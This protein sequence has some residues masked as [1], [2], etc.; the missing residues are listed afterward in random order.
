MENAPANTSSGPKSGKLWL[1]FIL[2][3]CSAA[4]AAYLGL[5][6]MSLKQK[7][8]PP[9]KAETK[10]PTEQ[11]LAPARIAPSFDA[12]TAD[13]WGGLVAAGQAEPGTI[14]LLQNQGQTL[15]EAKADEHGEWVLMLDHPLPPGNYDLSLQAVRPQTQEPIAGP[16]H[17]AL[18]IAPRE[19]PAAKPAQI[20][21][22]SPPKAGTAAPAASARVE[23]KQAKPRVAAVKRGD[24]LWAMAHRFYG[25][26]IRYGEIAGANKEQ[27]KDPNLIYPNQQ[28]AIPEEKAP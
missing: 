21:A 14:V 8:T 23:L 25:K 18:T 13:E 4:S 17:F 15:G 5:Q 6:P 12:V 19:K 7:L 2:L 28:L 22:A 1:V 10:A 27:I 3:L 16:H 26:G 11:A 24:T 20:A 9:P